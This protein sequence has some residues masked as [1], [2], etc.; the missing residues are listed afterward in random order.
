MVS[1]KELKVALFLTQNNFVRYN[2]HKQASIKFAKSRCVLSKRYS[3][4]R[5]FIADV[6]FLEKREGR[7]GFQRRNGTNLNKFLFSWKVI[8]Y[9]VETCVGGR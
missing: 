6:F 1:T 2:I 3:P 4:E 5:S 8:F 7:G 9:F